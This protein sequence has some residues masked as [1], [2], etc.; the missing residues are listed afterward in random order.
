MSRIEQPRSTHKFHYFFE[1]WKRRATDEWDEPMKKNKVQHNGSLPSIPET[2]KRKR[3]TEVTVQ[4]REHVIR[5]KTD[6]AQ[7]TLS[8]SL[9]R[10]RDEEQKAADCGVYD[11][12]EKEVLTKAEVTR[13]L[14]KQRSLMELRFS[15]YMRSIVQRLEAHYKADEGFTHQPAYIS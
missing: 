1:M 11:V 3:E 6:W 5:L 13:L 8:F 10:V 15:H 14:T 9:K 4:I 2:K 12:P 7:E